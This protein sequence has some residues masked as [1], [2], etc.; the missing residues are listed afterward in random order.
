MVADITTSTKVVFPQ[1]AP[2]YW[3]NPE[4]VN[5][6]CFARASSSVPF[7]FQPL[8]VSGVSGIEEGRSKWAKLA[9]YDSCLPEKVLF[10]DGGLLSS[11]PV[12]LF[13]RIGVPRAP[14]LGAQFGSCRRSVNKTSHILEYLQSLYGSQ[15]HYMSYDFILQNPLYQ[16][17][18]AHIS[19]ANYFWLDFNLSP[20]DKL[21]LFREGVKAG[22]AF[23]ESFNW[24]QYKALRAAEQEMIKTVKHIAKD[25]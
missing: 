25:A 2:M 11:F 3:Q 4:E 9:S 8:E 6:A 15:L 20:E 19:T 7:F 18:V 10:T 17:L 1:M 23:L 14:T 12:E 21:C 24:P 5:P 22:Y 13:K 16:R